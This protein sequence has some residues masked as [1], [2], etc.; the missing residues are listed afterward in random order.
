M[1]SKMPEPRTTT[2]VQATAGRRPTADA[3]T[4]AVQQTAADLAAATI[5]RSGRRLSPGAAFASITAI[6]VVFMAA[7]SAPSPLYVV[8]QQQWGFSATTLTIIF[9]VYVLGLIGSLLVLGALS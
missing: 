5:P 4:E 6:F 7:S 3:L 2:D 9:A 8:Y 1:R